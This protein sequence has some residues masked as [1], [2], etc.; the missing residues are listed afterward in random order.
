M[1]KRNGRK[2]E[3]KDKQKWVLDDCVD[4]KG[5]VPLRAATGVR[6]ASLF[7]LGKILPLYLTSLLFWII[8]TNS[9]HDDF[10]SWLQIEKKIPFHCI[11]SLMKNLYYQ[12]TQNLNGQ[13]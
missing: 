12:Y 8:Y 11:N 5:R 2:S 4:Y 3:E 7:V 13:I 6:K 9:D 1:E 10:I